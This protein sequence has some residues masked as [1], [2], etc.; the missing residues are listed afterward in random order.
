MLLILVACA[1]L[2]IL[3]VVAATFSM[4]WCF[5]VIR[6]RT[7]SDS[8]LERSELSQLSVTASAW[9]TAAAAMRAQHQAQQSAAPQRKGVSMD[10]LEVRSHGL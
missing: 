4:S 7:T 9:A 1:L 3:L 8:Y 5:N 6:E 10:I 2:I